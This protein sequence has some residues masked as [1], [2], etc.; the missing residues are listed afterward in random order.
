M[1]M[2]IKIDKQ[3]IKVIVQSCKI[4]TYSWQ[5]STIDLILTNDECYYLITHNLCI[6]YTNSS[7]YKILKS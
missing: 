2:N 6:T 7:N 5:L 3:Y 1:A 4:I